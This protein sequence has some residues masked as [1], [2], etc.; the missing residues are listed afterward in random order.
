MISV[1]LHEYIKERYDGIFEDSAYAA[2]LYLKYLHDD[3]KTIVEKPYG[4]YTYKFIGDALIISDIFILKPMRD[5]A[6]IIEMVNELRKIAQNN[7]KCS[8]IIGFSEKV[9]PNRESGIKIM[10]VTEFIPLGEEENR[11]IY[12]RGT[13]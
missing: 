9:G 13:Q 11:T 7:P 1:F 4:F 3:G 2:A 10:K 5:S 6:K 8:V 12:I